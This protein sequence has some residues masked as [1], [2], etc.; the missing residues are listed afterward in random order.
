MPK[1]KFLAQIISSVEICR[2]VGRKK[3]SDLVLFLTHDA[4]CWWKDSMHISK[5]LPPN[6]YMALPQVG[7]GCATSIVMD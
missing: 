5:N 4:A 7:L 6:N 1:S 2:S 3:F